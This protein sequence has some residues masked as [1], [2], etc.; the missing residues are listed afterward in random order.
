MAGQLI[1]SAAAGHTALLRGTV[2]QSGVRL[3]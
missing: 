2:K 1:H 3:D